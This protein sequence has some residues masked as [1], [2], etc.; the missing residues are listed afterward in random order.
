MK[1][2]SYFLN[3]VTALCGLALL[4]LF[5]AP[6]QKM[7]SYG[8]PGLI[9]LF[10][11]LCFAAL[12]CGN[13]DEFEYRGMDFGTYIRSRRIPYGLLVTGLAV[14]FWART[15]VGL[16]PYVLFFGGAF[17]IPILL[18]VLVL[19]LLS[20]NWRG[21]FTGLVWYCGGVIVFYAA[22][23]MQMAGCSMLGFRVV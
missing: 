7:V 20:L 23:V 18:A 6:Y 1:Y 19:A 17:Y 5:V 11:V 8:A 21:L 13:F 4:G 10:S 16:A 9:P 3:A 2:F 12:Y 15:G 14:F 22:S